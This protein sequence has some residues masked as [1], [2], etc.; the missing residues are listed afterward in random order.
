MTEISAADRIRMVLE[1]KT[2]N[3]LEL[4][5]L[6][7]LDP[8]HDFRNMDLDGVDLSNCNLDGF[9]LAGAK[10]FTSNFYNSKISKVNF[11]SQQKE[12]DCLRE[13]S[14]YWYTQNIDTSNEMR[15]QN[16]YPHD[17]DKF[18][19]FI[20]WCQI[21]YFRGVEDIIDEIPDI[22]SRNSKE[23]LPAIC[24]ACANGHDEIIRL[25]IDNGADVNRASKLGAVSPLMFACL[26]DH[27]NIVEM[28]IA[29][30]ADVEHTTSQDGFAA[31][32]EL[33][34]LLVKS[35]FLPRQDERSRAVSHKNFDRFRALML[36]AHKDIPRPLTMPRYH[37]TLAKFSGILGGYNSLTIASL[38]GRHEVVK[39]LVLAGA[40]VNSVTPYQNFTPLMIACMYRQTSVIEVLCSH[41]SLNL[42]QR[43][44]SGA[45]ALAFAA[46]QNH[47]RGVVL[48]INA[49]A[50]PLEVTAVAHNASDLVDESALG[51]STYRLLKK[52]ESASAL[53][54]GD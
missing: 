5:E 17:D 38:A 20:N 26:E 14:D 36:D 35:Q 31:L 49:G 37:K 30:G 43:S 42:N 53:K 44:R 11:D 51:R 25:L 12:L 3:F 48:L 33:R 7:G 2:E 27:N 34:H 8:A 1:A 54:H 45:T 16:S 50:N 32:I 22:N 21:G 18:V 39:Q 29:N 40:D 46:S 23:G 13:A 41:T 9:D 28:L 47:Y 6:S 52:A 4:V 10:I 19:T 24:Y 15:G